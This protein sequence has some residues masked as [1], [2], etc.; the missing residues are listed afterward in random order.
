[1]AIDAKIHGRVVRV[2]S[3]HLE[4]I[5]PPVQIAQALELLSGPAQ[6]TLPLIMLG[7]FNS[8]ADGSTT[9]TYGLLTAAGLVDTWNAAHPGDPGLTC[10]Q[11]AD[12][13]NATYELILQLLSRYFANTDE[14]PEQLATLADV[15][16]GLMY[17]AVKP[18]GDLV[19]RLPVGPEQPGRTAGPALELRAVAGRALRAC[20]PYI[21]RRD[22]APASARRPPRLGSVTMHLNGVEIRDSSGWINGQW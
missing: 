15:A 6:T 4:P 2:V 5:S 16:V 20:A 14:S 7:D 10:C 8:A 12:L 13:L 21:A 3:T 22:S 1:M 11:A 18:L 19:T 17:T 9:A